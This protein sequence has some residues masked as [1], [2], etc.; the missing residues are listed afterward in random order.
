MKELGANLR[1]LLEV[2]CALCDAGGQFLV[3]IKALLT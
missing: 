2:P 3:L 1:T